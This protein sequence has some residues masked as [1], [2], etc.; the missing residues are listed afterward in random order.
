MTPGLA[1]QA[2]VRKLIDTFPERNHLDAR[3]VESRTALSFLMRLQHEQLPVRV[4][5]A[6]EIRYVSA[7]TATGLIE[8]EIGALGATARYAASRLAIVIRITE[9]G[10]AEIARS[11]HVP[12]HAATSMKFAGGP[13]FM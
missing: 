10:C 12:K 1:D 5:E 6:E 3:R 13:R 4:V 7:L 11:G 8:A 2:A 9:H